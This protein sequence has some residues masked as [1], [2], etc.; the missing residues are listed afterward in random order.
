MRFAL[1][2]ITIALTISLS[3]PTLAYKETSVSNGGSVSGKIVLAG[4]EP[5]P[6]AFSLITNNKP[7]RSLPT[8]TQNFA[9]VFRPATAGA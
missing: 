3:S 2:F 1:G 8:I 5:P 9:D 7:F 4:K 6:L